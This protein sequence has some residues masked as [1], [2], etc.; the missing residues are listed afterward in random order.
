MRTLKP[1]RRAPRIPPRAARRCA[2]VWLV[3][4]VALLGCR[5]NPYVLPACAP[6]DPAAQP[7]HTGCVVDRV[8]LVGADAVPAGEIEPHLATAQSSH[9][10]GGVLERVPILG[11]LD[12]LAADYERFD[13]FV[14]E[15][16]LARVE[17]AYRARGHYEARVRAGRV[18]KL[19]NGHVRV[20]IVVTEGEPV[21]VAAVDLAWKDSCPFDKALDPVT[22]AVTNVKNKLALG[23]PFAEESFEAT[24]G[25]I[26]AELADRG[27]AYAT[28][29]KHADVDLAQH[30]ARVRYTIE[31]GPRTK[32]GDIRFEGLVRAEAKDGRGEVLTG[33]EDPLR[34]LLGFETEEP[35]RQSLLDSAQLALTD[36]GVFSSIELI[37]APGQACATLPADCSKRPVVAVPIIVRVEVAKLRT[38]KLGIGA[39]AGWQVEGHGVAGWED[40]NFVGGL[41]HFVAEAKGGPVLYPTR[42][43]T[44]FSAPP[45]RILPQL[46]LRTELSQPLPWRT[47][48]HFAGSFNLYRLQPTTGSTEATRPVYDLDLRGPT[49]TKFEPNIIGYREYTGRSGVDRSFTR[50]RHYVGLFYNLQLF[51]PFSYNEPDAPIGYSN[52]LVPYAQIVG[53]LDFRRGAR[54]LP[55]RIHPRSGA[56]LSVDAQLASGASQDANDAR[57]RP[58]LRGFVAISQRVTL[59]SRLAFGFLFPQNYGTQLSG[60]NAATPEECHDLQLLQLRGFFSGGPYSNRGYGYNEVGPH[61]TATCS[62]Q[63]STVNQ[64]TATGGL[65]MWEASLELRVPLGESLGTALFVDGSDVTGCEGLVRF[66]HPHLSTGL[67]LRYDTPVGPLRADVGWRIPGAQA[68]DAKRACAR[69]LPDLEPAPVLGLPIAVSVAIGEAF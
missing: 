28:V 51:S 64:S 31:L 8:E 5:S 24:R 27:F 7:S 17:R 43:D 20:E 11:I 13:R 23:E 36:L 26:Q 40:R 63:V 3:L 45:T 19:P 69:D 59:A 34:R 22:R 62:A 25:A 47:T 1:S 66:T 54:G 9:P 21:K 15:R 53:T 33:A 61:V 52:V 48:L 42:L 18:T 4:A 14:L 6:N 50:W 16:D 29:D 68:L 35:F 12:R 41:R 46:K 55:D 65:S 30:A 32:F 56:W 49:L 37:K 44:L 60:G 57:I 10:L 38:V 67:G 58:E 2:V 39:E